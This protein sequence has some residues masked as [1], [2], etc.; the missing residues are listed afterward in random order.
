MVTHSSA[1]DGKAH[2]C[3][4]LAEVVIVKVYAQQAQVANT[5]DWRQA[6]A[7]ACSQGALTADIP[8]DFTITNLMRS[9]AHL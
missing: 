6:V 5:S 4:G 9:A 8:Q 1:K 3:V 7:Y 2:G